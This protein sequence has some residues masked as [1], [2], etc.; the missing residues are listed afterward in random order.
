MSLYGDG[1]INLKNNRLVKISHKVVRIG[2]SN[3]RQIK[4]WEYQMDWFKVY[5]N[6]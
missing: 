5:I 1:L 4:V 3:L 6:Q 2:V